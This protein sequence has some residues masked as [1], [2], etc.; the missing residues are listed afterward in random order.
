MDTTFLQARIDATKAQIEIYEDAISA[1][2]I[3]GAQEYMLDTGQSR[4][5]VTK[6]DLKSLNTVLDSLV[7][8]LVVYEQRLTGNGNSIGR[9]AW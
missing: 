7:N 5:R 9:P 4:Q 1:L 6:L 8:R 2:G 3:G